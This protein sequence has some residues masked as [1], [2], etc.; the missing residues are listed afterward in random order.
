MVAFPGSWVD[1]AHSLQ[2]FE[3]TVNQMSIPAELLY[4]ISHQQ[5]EEGALRDAGEAA[6]PR[7]E[8]KPDDLSEVPL[9]LFGH[10][11]RLLTAT[12]HADRWNAIASGRDED[13]LVSCL[14]VTRER[15]ALALRAIR[16]FQAQTYPRKEL[17]IV[18]DDPDHTL[19]DAVQALGDPRIVHLCETSLNRPL[20]ALRNQAVERARG[21]FVCQ[22]DD[23]DLSHPER[24][25]MQMAAIQVT[26][27]D[28]CT[29]VRQQLLFPDRQ[30]FAISVRRIWESSLVCA[31][32]KL[33]RYPE[34]RRGED[35]PVTEEIVRDCHVALLDAPSLYT[36]VFHGGNTFDAEHFEAHWQSATER[37]EGASYEV[38]LGA[39]CAALPQ[40]AATDV[41][42]SSQA[43]SPEST[44]M[45]KV[46]P[47]QCFGDVFAL[48]QK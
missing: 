38:K 41:L 8:E 39:L 11:K 2:P 42:T 6:N 30:R 47:S 25:A 46:Y 40:E 44:F 12:L 1:M 10:G 16:C 15:L 33:P 28:A 43:V 35:T 17:V 32:N 48:R 5:S 4:P 37:H 19:R 29:L 45:P 36:Y 18:D 13:P 7:D 14:M 9:W 24:L 21:E 31:K 34:L 22:W 27:A 26:R 3:A 23:D 20:G